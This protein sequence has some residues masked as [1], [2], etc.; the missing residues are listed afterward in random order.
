MGAKKPSDV[1]WEKQLEKVAY[2]VSVL[3]VVLMFCGSLR[4]WTVK[5][6]WLQ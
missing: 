4:R 3:A 2:I 1:E 6:K 5:Y